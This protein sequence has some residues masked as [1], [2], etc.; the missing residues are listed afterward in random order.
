MKI[1]KYDHLSVDELLDTAYNELTDADELALALM[2]RLAEVRDEY[3]DYKEDSEAE[4]AHEY[5]KNER[6]QEELDDLEERYL[7]FLDN[8]EGS[9][10]VS[11]D[12]EASK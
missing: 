6:L 2:I 3:A 8:Q 11:F 5:Q 4:L 7:R 1:T 10:G 9:S 12:V